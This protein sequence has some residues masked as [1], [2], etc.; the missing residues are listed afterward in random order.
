MFLV[1]IVN[2]F[3]GNVVFVFVVYHEQLV[4]IVYYF[5]LFVFYL[6]MFV[7]EY[8]FGVLWVGDLGGDFVCFY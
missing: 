1:L 5:L 7:E 2:I 8:V 4:R 6:D 3:F